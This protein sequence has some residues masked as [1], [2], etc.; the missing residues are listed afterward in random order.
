M[1][2]EV[3]ALVLV[4]RILRRGEGQEKAR[5]GRSGEVKGA[6]R[7]EGEGGGGAGGDMCDL[8]LGRA[9][10]SRQHEHVAA[11]CLTPSMLNR[12]A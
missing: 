9:C 6:S 8:A 1:H 3:A 4:T 2:V 11:R 12:L 5:E 10:G 7:A